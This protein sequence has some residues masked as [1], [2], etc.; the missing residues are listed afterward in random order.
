MCLERP[1]PFWPDSLPWKRSLVWIPPNR[2]S[3]WPSQSPPWGWE[4]DLIMVG[5]IKILLI[6]NLE[7]VWLIACYE[8]LLIMC[9]YWQHASYTHAHRNILFCGFIEE[10]LESRQG[11]SLSLWRSRNFNFYWI[12]VL[13]L[14]ILIQQLNIFMSNFSL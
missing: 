13:M 8:M 10:I 7:I 14:R 1:L 11:H 2:R 9:I 5:R 12:V 4:R 3:Q 6:L